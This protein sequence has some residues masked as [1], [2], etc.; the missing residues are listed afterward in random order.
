MYCKKC[1]SPNA[2]GEKVCKSCGTPLPGAAQP[3]AQSI[4]DKLKGVGLVP[5]IGCGVAFIS[6]FLPWVVPIWGDSLNVFSAVSEGLGGADIGL[7]YYFCLFSSIFVL[8]VPVVVVFKYLTGRKKKGDDIGAVIMPIAWVLLW[9]SAMS[10]ASGMKISFVMEL[11]DLGF[12]FWLYLIAMVATVI[13][14]R[15]AGKAQK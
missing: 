15:M 7:M 4:A 9:F 8:A 5:V 3:G 14:C 13:G 10:L 2:D 1:G 6:C 12:G 11:I